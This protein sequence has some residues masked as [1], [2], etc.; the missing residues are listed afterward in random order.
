MRSTQANFPF[1]YFRVNRLGTF[2]ISAASLNLC[3]MTSPN[4]EWNSTTFTSAAHNP[5][6]GILQTC[7]PWSGNVEDH[8]RI[9]STTVLRCPYFLHSIISLW[10][11]GIFHVLPD[12]QVVLSPFHS[13]A[14]LVS[15]IRSWTIQHLSLYVPAHS[16][17]WVW[18]SIN[19]SCIDR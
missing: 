13:L 1:D 2:I 3:L 6:E 7:I 19:L 18:C 10:F 4:H 14:F 16:L 5:G 12:L 15:S 11:S 9:P 17:A 8:L